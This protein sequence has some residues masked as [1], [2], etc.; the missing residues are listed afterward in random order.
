MY[1]VQQ[2][3][4]FFFHTHL[5]ITNIKLKHIV[6]SLVLIQLY[7]NELFPVI[8]TFRSQRN[9]I[10]HKLHHTYLNSNVQTI[11]CGYD[12]GAASE[13]DS[14][15]SSWSFLLFLKRAHVIVSDRI[16]R[17]HATSIAEHAYALSWLVGCWNTVMPTK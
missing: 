13:K 10:T 8:V 7:M 6:L 17:I 2:Y 14:I 16:Q 5:N 4:Y 15:L 12:S 9:H 3:I 11:S 1:H